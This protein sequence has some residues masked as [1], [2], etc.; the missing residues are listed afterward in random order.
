MH[1]HLEL[2]DRVQVEREAMHHQHETERRDLHGN[3]REEHRK[4]HERH[5]KAHKEMNERHLA[6]MNQAALG[7]G[8]EGSGGLFRERWCARGA[9]GPGSTGHTRRGRSRCRRRLAMM[10]S[11]ELEDDDKIDHVTASPMLNSDV[12]YGLRIALTEQEFEKL[13]L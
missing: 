13:G 7:P 9:A 1:P 10:K 12:P 6:E 4:M 11:M 5:Q 2:H 8:N 3:H